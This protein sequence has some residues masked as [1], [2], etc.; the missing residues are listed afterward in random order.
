MNKTGFGFLRL[1]RLEDGSIDYELL[2]PMVDRFLA[3]GGTYFDTA[4]TYLDGLSEEAIRKAVTERHPRESFLLADKLPGYMV[5]TES[6]CNTYFQEQLRRCG[7]NYFD[8]Y[9]LHWLTEANYEIAQRFGEFAFLQELKATG[10]AKKIGFSY[11]DSPELLERILQDH[12]EVD[13]VQLQINYL[14][15]DS[16]TLQAARLWEVAQRHGKEIVVME[17]V[18]GGKLANIPQEAAARLAALGKPR[19]PAFHAIRFASSLPQVSVVLSG[20]NAMA[21]LQENMTHFPAVT[22]EEKA[23]LFQCASIIRDQTAVGCTGCGY[24]LPH[25]PMEIPIPNLFTLYNDYARDPQEGW[26]MQ[27]VYDHAVLKGG[28][29]SACLGCGRCESHCPQQLPIR[30]FLP[31]IAEVFEPRRV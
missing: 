21:Q 16:P 5:K 24:C 8:V 17:P 29:A 23:I 27:H 11:H 2:N 7:V 26:K 14:D 1:P 4:Y 10:K 9:L 13:I 31:K 6:D 25:C 3:L 18:K 20:M 22:E 15:W 28:K 30:E 19:S 12:P